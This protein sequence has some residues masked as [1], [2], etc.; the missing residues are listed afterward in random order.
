[1][2][3]EQQPRNAGK[4]QVEDAEK[5]VETT[6][7]STPKKAELTKRNADFMFR[8]RKELADQKIDADKLKQALDDTEA[9]LLEGQKKGQTAKQLFGTP[10]EHM[11]EIVHGP[12][13]QIGAQTTDNLWLR[14]VDNGL[15]FMALFSAMYALMAFFQPAA[16]VKSPGPAGLL[17]IIGTSAVGGIGMGYVYKWL[18]PSS[19]GGKR[20]T[21]WRQI[22]V[23]TAAV[24]A[25]IVAYMVFSVIPSVINPTLPAF[26]YVILAALAF[27]G[28]WLF[29]RRYNIVGGLF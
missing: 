19:N 7:A 4:Q 6:E 21:F 3:E 22:G 1:M 13:R 11:Q 23:T 26:G 16:I 18:Y 29:R 20:P 8:L 25:W 27:G 12:K 14:A 10:T 17:A 24:L 28:R 15:I 2:S 9:K 5:A